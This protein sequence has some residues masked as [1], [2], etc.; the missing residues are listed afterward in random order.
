MNQ[1]SIYQVQADALISQLKK[2]QEASIRKLEHE[3]RDWN[4]QRLR[5]ARHQALL[6]FRK[7]A[8]MER[9]SFSREI[10][11]AE[12]A[13]AAEAR[14]RHQHHLAAMVQAVINRLPE[15]LARRWS[16]PLHRT[17]WIEAALHNAVQRL[18]QG[19]W[20]IRIAPGPGEDELPGLFEGASIEWQADAALKAGLVIEKGG[21]R[22]DA[23]ISGLLADSARVQ[24]HVLTLLGEV[25]GGGRIH[26]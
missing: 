26:V 21:A 23:S 25:R 15:A 5:E 22:L 2:D 14:S 16:S 19:T 18:G 10:S 9:E 24:S 6:Q 3:A 17:E 20:R 4:R 13:V 7:A 11:A 8:A 12:A 1:T